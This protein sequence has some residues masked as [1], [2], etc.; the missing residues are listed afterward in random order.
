MFPRG[1]TL[2]I[3]FSLLEKFAYMA[4]YMYRLIDQDILSRKSSHKDI[5][6]CVILDILVNKVN[7]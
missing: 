5:D 6:F 3:K 2:S 7:K 1:S 4:I